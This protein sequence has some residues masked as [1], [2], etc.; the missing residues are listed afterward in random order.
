MQTIN[1]F[2]PSFLESEPRKDRLPT[3]QYT[4]GMLKAAFKRP[5]DWHYRLAK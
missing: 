2:R 5:L 3:V 1:L 4:D